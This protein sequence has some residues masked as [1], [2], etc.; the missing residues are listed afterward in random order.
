MLPPAI[1]TPEPRVLPKSRASLVDMLCAPVPRGFANDSFNG[2]HNLQQKSFNGVQ[3][4]KPAQSTSTVTQASTT[5][6]SQTQ[7]SIP[8]EKKK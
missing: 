4:L 2:V 7:A 3:Q 1:C 8:T 5:Q 6:A